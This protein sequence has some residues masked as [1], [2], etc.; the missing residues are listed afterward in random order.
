MSTIYLIGSLRN[1]KIPQIGVILRADG[2][3]VFD[4]WHAG[5][6]EA[7]DEWKRYE[8]IR[9]RSYREAL[10][11]YPAWHTFDYDRH[12]IHRCDV[13]VLVCPAGKSG[14]LELGYMIGRGQRGYILLEGEPDPD[15]WDLMY[16]FA[17]G[18]AL[19]VEELQEMVR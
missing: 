6:K 4:D 18:I 15:R 10:G 2:H 1:A 3:D 7:D 5:G 12:H 17:H 8:Q 19:D 13:G 9:G 11:G 14:H 16:K